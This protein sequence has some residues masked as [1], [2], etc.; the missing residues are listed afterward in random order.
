MHAKHHGRLDLSCVTFLPDEFYNDYPGLTEAITCLL[1]RLL[2]VGELQKIFPDWS[3][4][5]QG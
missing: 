3:S 4:S 5:P 2:L 1:N